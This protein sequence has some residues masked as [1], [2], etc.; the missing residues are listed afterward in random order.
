MCVFFSFKLI[1]LL[2][3][4]FLITKTFILVNLQL[5]PGWMF[6]TRCSAEWK[7]L[8]EAGG[9]TVLSGARVWLLQ[10]VQSCGRRGLQFTASELL[11]PWIWFICSQ[12]QMTALTQDGWRGHALL[13]DPLAASLYPGYDKLCFTLEERLLQLLG[14]DRALFEYGDW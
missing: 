13:T 1:L 6:W 10:R 7:C 11:Q 14:W 5:A 12:T 3:I 4:F 9:Q 8:M 2:E